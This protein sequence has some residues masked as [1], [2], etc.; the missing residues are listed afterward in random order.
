[1]SI[2]FDG[3]DDLMTY[4]APVTP[5]T[6]GTLLIVCKI[7]NTNDSAWLSFIEGEPSGGGTPNYALGRRNTGNIYYVTPV[8]VIDGGAVQD[9]DGWQIIATTKATGSSAVSTH[10]MPI[11]GARTTT[12]LAAAAN[13]GSSTNGSIKIGGDDDFANI[14]VAAVAIFEGTALTTGQLDAILAAKTTASIISAGATWCVDAADGL[15]NDLVGSVD[16]TAVV[17]TASSADNPSG[18]TYASSSADA[19]VTAVPAAATG[20]SPAAVISTLT[21]VAGVPAAAT[22]DNPAAVATASAG[23]DTF[24]QPDGTLGSPWSAWTS[25][26]PAL[27]GGAAYDGGSLGDATYSV[28][29]ASAD[30]MME[31]I[32]ESAITAGGTENFGVGV[33]LTAH[34]GS[35]N[36]YMFEAANSGTGVTG[37][38]YKGAAFTP[39]ATSALNNYTNVDGL[40][41]TAVGTTIKGYLRVSGSWTEVVSATDATYSAAGYPGFWVQDPLT[42]VDVGVEQVSWGAPTAS[43]TVTAVPAVALGSAPPAGVSSA[44]NA[45]VTAVPAAATGDNPAAVISAGA[46]VTGVVALALGSAPPANAILSAVVGAPAVVALGSAPIASVSGAGAAT[47]TAVPA[48]ALASAPIASLSAGQVVVGVVADGTGAA[49][50]AA[51][52]LGATVLGVPAIAVGSATRSTLSPSPAGGGGVSGDVAATFA[53]ASA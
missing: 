31:A 14:L 20:D 45:T 2:L 44:T 16:R 25:T 46:T 24:E 53:E 50:P 8:T 35:A 7:V 23:T 5:Y 32:L 38:I 27:I 9:A 4:S 51:L 19:T 11:G 39:V 10:K 42:G 43:A 28:I 49:P 52:A 15:I 13:A 36:G 41:I 40:R 18:W 17:G 47:V 30:S 3:V 48:T 33:R 34:S 37:K 12:T 21:A 29:A 6:F 26:M 22:G 1:M